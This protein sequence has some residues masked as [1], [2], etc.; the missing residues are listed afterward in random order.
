MGLCLSWASDRIRGPFFY[1]IMK[2]NKVFLLVIF[3]IFFIGCLVFNYLFFKQSQNPSVSET[4]LKTSCLLVSTPGDDVLVEGDVF[5]SDGVKI[6]YWFYD[7]GTETVTIFLHGGPGHDTYD[8]RDTYLPDGYADRF[9]S[10]LLF[11]QRGSGLSDNF[12]TNKNLTKEDINFDRFIEDINELREC[13]IPGHPVI[14]WGRS[15]GGLLA[16][17]YADSHPKGVVAYLLFSPGVF[18]REITEKGGEDI[19]A[20][21]NGIAIL[22]NFITVRAE[23]KEKELLVKEYNSRRPKH[24][25]GQKI[26][27]SDTPYDVAE[28]IYNAGIAMEENEHLLEKNFYY[29]LTAMKNLPVF[30]QYGGYDT[31]VPPL[32]IE[33]MKPYLDLATYFEIPE[34]DHFAAYAH[35]DEVYDQLELF[36]LNNKIDGLR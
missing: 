23:K 19:I 2:K 17:A 30:I 12:A 1:D 10:L 29:F 20:L 33:A 28:A 16:A 31:I 5:T 34:E 22:D 3:F 26:P 32:A 9:G 35:P 11:D 36:Y 27:S 14:I 6:H 18:D 4:W 25:P 13:I 15:F 7:R 8:F 21:N 24:D